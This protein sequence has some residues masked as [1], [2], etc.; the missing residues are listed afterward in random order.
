MSTASPQMR[1]FVMRVAQRVL[2]PYTR[3]NQLQSLVASQEIDA[4]CRYVAQD[5]AERALR[6]AYRPD[7][8]RNGHPFRVSPPTGCATL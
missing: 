3:D 6:D 1:R 5:P 4:Q 7:R 2:P 8:H